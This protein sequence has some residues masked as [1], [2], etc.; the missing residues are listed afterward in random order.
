MEPT[1]TT[2][3]TPETAEVEALE[4]DTETAEETI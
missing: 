4:V 2:I 3:D 1:E